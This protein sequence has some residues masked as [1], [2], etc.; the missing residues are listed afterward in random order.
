[1]CRF[2]TGAWAHGGHPGGGA[3]GPR[4]PVPDLH[5]LKDSDGTSLYDVLKS[6]DLDPEKIDDAAYNGDLNDFI[7]GYLR[8]RARGKKDA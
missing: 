8:W 4:G 6:R 5:R 3:A 2:G 7:M 1:M